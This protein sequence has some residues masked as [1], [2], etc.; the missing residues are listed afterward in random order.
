MKKLIKQAFTLIELLV[1]IAIIGILSGLIV[2]SMSG[3]TN[4]ANIAKAQV[5]SNSLRN[6][7]MLNLV[8]E[9]KFDELTTASNGTAIIDSWSGNTGTLITDNT[10]TEKLSSDCI[11]GKC[12]RLDG[13]GDY[14]SFSFV[15]GVVTTEN[16]TI[17]TWIKKTVSSSGTVI[18]I[19][20]SSSNRNGITFTA[21][22]VACGLYN[23]AYIRFISTFDISLNVWHYITCVN[24]STVL[25]LYIDGVIATTEVGGLGLAGSQNYIGYNSNDPSYFNGFIDDVRIYN[26]A[27]PT[28]QIKEQYYAGLNKLLT[29]GEITEE[30]YSQ[31]IEGMRISKY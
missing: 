24:R 13:T 4:K 25:V 3:V 22:R 26:T 6:S 14:I 2:I 17:G 28:S 16:Y 15:P 31:R 29:N 19:S 10:T 12:L 5:F 9:W 11:S 27:I 1:V 8:S 7:L 18:N 21:N 20:N 23:T 30:E